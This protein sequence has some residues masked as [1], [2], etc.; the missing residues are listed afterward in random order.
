MM[1]NINL[2]R[3]Q[4]GVKANAVIVLNEDIEELKPNYNIESSVEDRE[5]YGI[6][7]GK[8]IF[9]EDI[10]K[11]AVNNEI[12]Y[13]IISDIDKEEKEKQNR[14]IGLVKDREIMGYKLPDNIILVFTV[15]NENDI[16]K[17]SGELYRFCTKNV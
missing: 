3:I 7:N 15:E 13:L 11:I 14:V 5:L 4:R 16:R 17:I 1:L 6:D 9:E 8:P 10:G 12:G 2:L